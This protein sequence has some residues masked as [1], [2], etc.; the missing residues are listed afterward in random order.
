LGFHA[1]AFI[2][3]WRHRRGMTRT[4]LIGDI[5][6]IVTL[7]LGITPP[8]GSYSIDALGSAIA[9][10]LFARSILDAHLFAPMQRLNAALRASNARLTTLSEGLQATT[11]EL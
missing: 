4:L 6:I 8:L 11:K 9:S 1:G 7:L 3:I 10:L 2:V 5:V